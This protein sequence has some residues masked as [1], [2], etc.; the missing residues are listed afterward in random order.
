MM[1]AGDSFRKILWNFG[2]D[3]QNFLKNVLLVVLENRAKELLNNCDHK[4]NPEK[5]NEFYLKM[6]KKYWEI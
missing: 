6:R 4:N 3:E 5:V 2:T 1:K